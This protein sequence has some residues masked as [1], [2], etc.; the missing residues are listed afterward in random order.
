MTK[1]TRKINELRA[2]EKEFK[3]L[4]DEFKE[5]EEKEKAE[6]EAT[7]EKIDKLIE[8]RYFCGII[9]T[10]GLLIDYLKIK[11][12]NPLANIKINYCLINEGEDDGKI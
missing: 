7:K 8:G 6:K 9:L 5:F 2:K 11:L 10:E 12:E 4:H 1:R 3:A